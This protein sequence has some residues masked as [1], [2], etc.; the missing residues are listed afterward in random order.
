LPSLLACSPLELQGSHG[1]P[2]GEICEVRLI[3]LFSYP[4][5]VHGIEFVA[6]IAL[7]K[8]SMHPDSRIY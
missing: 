6:R 1:G 8:F 3:S 4:L 7:T 5:V 2:G